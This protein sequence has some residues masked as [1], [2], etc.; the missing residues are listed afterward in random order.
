MEHCE[1][2]SYVA[3]RTASARVPGHSDQP[4]IDLCCFCDA[5]LSEKHQAA[6]Q[7]KHCFEVAYEVS[8][9]C[10]LIFRPAADGP[11]PDTTLL[12]CTGVRLWAVKG[13]AV[14]VDQQQEPGGH[15]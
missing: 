1:C 14:D 2:H 15:A 13:A 10:R 9:A 5:A 4:S 8:F 7:L 6:Q 11:R 3:D 12:V